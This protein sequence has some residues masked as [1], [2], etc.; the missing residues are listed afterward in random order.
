MLGKSFAA[1]VV[2]ERAR[3]TILG[4]FCEAEIAS[5][6]PGY[7]LASLPTVL[8]HP[9]LPRPAPATALQGFNNVYATTVFCGVILHYHKIHVFLLLF[10]GE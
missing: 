8:P 2:E 1:L 9:I 4:N 7:V 6:S 5:Y 3:C 10:F